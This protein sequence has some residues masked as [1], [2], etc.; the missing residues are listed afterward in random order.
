LRLVRADIYFGP[1]G[2]YVYGTRAVNS[3]H[4]L[5]SDL[6]HELDAVRG[7]PSR[8]GPADIVLGLRP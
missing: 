2:G 3:D 8:F 6:L 7:P 1:W 4:Q 5:F